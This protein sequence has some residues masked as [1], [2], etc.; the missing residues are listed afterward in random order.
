MRSDSGTLRHFHLQ[1]TS[2][3]ELYRNYPSIVCGSMALM[4]P[5]KAG[6]WSYPYPVMCDDA[7]K[8][9]DESYFTDMSDGEQTV[10]NMVSA[11]CGSLYLSGRIDFCDEYNKAL[12]KE[13]IETF[14]SYRGMIKRAY[15]VFP[16]GQMSINKR[17][18]LALGLVDQE[19]GEMILALWNIGAKE[20]SVS[21]DLSRFEKDTSS[22]ELIYPREDTRVSFSFDAGRLNVDF[23]SRDG[24]FARMFKIK[25]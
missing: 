13:A 14:K 10:F 16:L 19:A 15:P 8:E 17:G 7:T 22:A 3:Q 23:G 9:I 21:V 1:S 5:E 20:K 18:Y 2:D 4:P 12:I 25:F 24:Y 11:M 6:I